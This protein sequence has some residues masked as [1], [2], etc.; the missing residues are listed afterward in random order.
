MR[1]QDLSVAHAHPMYI[2]FPVSLSTVGETSY[3]IRVGLI[4]YYIF[5]TILYMYLFIYLFTPKV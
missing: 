2:E 5:L 1:Q 3:G 4:K